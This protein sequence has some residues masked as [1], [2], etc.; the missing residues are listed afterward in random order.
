MFEAAEL[1]RK[2]P[3]AEYEAALPEL[4]SRLLAAQRALRQ[5]SHSVLIIVSGVE[6]AG[7]SEVVNRLNE[8]LDAR[9]VT[10]HA[11]WEASDEER[12]RPRFWR[13][14]RALPPRG[15]IGVMF[16]SWYTQP[17][18]DRVFKRTSSA[19]LDR[20]MQRIAFF[21]RMLA[22]DGMV[23][24]KLWLHLPR[25]VQRERVAEKAKRR[26]KQW[27]FK[28]VAKEYAKKYDRFAAVSERAIRTTDTADAPWRIIEATDSRYR[29]LTVGRIVLEALEDLASPVERAPSAVSI[30]HADERGELSDP[31]NTVLDQV[32]LAQRIDDERYEKR[33]KKL[34]QELAELTWK[35]WDSRRPTVILFEG[36]DAAGKGGAIRRVIAPIDARLYNVISIAAPTDEERA[37]H[38]LW[39][40][41]R[42]LP[43]DGRIAIYDRSWY[44]RVL[45]ERVE[46]F[47]RVEEW[48][49][50]YREITE[51]EEQVVE[52]GT[53]L[54]K[55]WLHID[56]DE[57]LRR[58]QERQ[59]VAYKQHKITD[60]DWR[61]RE[62]WDPYKVAVHDMVS[63]TSSSSA[64]WD[65]IPAND[66]HLARVEVLDRLVRRLGKA[67]K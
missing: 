38:Y 29:D 63:R 55:F 7:K 53:V 42:H 49:R 3:K 27:L 26:K 61:N 67:L 51:F 52:H 14:W 59:E 17:I 36:W 6:G 12:D 2:T 35:A 60:E 28:E 22:E 1:R 15:S 11:F 65:I 64:P 46:G 47:A 20:E 23:V 54:L 48:S 10:T 16:G 66:K 37:R 39:R 13:F 5:T 43:R 58:F 19:D 9:G 25:D 30:A 62:K 41:W 21:E 4:R 45:V 44:G 34:Q 32:D 40:F 24:I 33:L 57:Q 18:V 8:W 31:K 56:P 50:A